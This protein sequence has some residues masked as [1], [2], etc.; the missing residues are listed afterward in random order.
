MMIVHNGRPIGGLALVA[1]RSSFMQVHARPPSCDLSAVA[2]GCCQRLIICPHAAPPPSNLSTTR[3]SDCKHVVRADLTDGP[4]NDF[5]LREILSFGVSS[6]S[7]DDVVDFS[8]PASWVGFPPR[9]G[10]KGRCVE[11]EG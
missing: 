10:H 5:V 4:P 6:T 11:A 1:G 8:C 7:S 9:T 3:V 2:A